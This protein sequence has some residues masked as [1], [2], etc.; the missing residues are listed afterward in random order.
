[1]VCGLRIGRIDFRFG[2]IFLTFQTNQLALWLYPSK[3]DDADTYPC[4][5]GTHPHDGDVTELK[6]IERFAYTFASLQGAW[7][8]LSIFSAGPLVCLLNYLMP[9]LWNGTYNIFTVVMGV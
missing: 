2:F 8:V 4:S 9:T 1:L 6:V 5:I 7:G 3:D